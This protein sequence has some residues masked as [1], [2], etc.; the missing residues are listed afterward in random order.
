MS[1]YTHLRQQS[2]SVDIILMMTHGDNSRSEAHS[3]RTQ[4]NLSSAQ[5]VVQSCMAIVE[6]KRKG[7]ITTME[8]ILGLL[9]TL[10]EGG[11]ITAFSHYVNQ[12]MEVKIEQETTHKQ[13][14]NTIPPIPR[15]D[16][17]LVETADEAP[18]VR[19]K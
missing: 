1:I 18:V 8:A 16:D 3:L 11:S 5:E 9:R 15:E 7:E 2:Y 10:P 14:S 6:Q 13:G 4:S 12:L 19:M 17:V